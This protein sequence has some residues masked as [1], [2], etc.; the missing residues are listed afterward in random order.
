VHPIQVDQYGQPAAIFI[1][2]Q[3]RLIG[4]NSYKWF[5]GGRSELIYQ[6]NGVLFWIAGDQND[7]IGEKVLWNLAQ[8]LSQT[9]PFNHYLHLIG[10]MPYISQANLSDILDPFTHDSLRIFPADDPASAYYI[11]VPFDQSE[12]PIPQAGTHGH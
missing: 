5:F 9:V 12:A 2:G 1:N 4:K 10:D 6:Q 3:W 11:S 8:S 7:G